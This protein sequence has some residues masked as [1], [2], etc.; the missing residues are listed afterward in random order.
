MF[1]AC[2][3]AR[4][5]MRELETRVFLPSSHTTGSILSVQS[6]RDKKMIDSIDISGIPKV[7]RR[8]MFTHA[9]TNHN[10]SRDH[11]NSAP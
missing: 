6:A 11:L 1:A 3:A 2:V 10:P 5:L 7:R 4:R 9:K 8:L